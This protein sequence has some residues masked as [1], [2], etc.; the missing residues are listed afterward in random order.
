MGN[1]FQVIKH[2]NRTFWTANTMELFERLAWYGMFIVLANYL[3]GSTDSGALGFSQAEKGLLMGSIVGF[4]Y[5]L[6]ILTGS[7]ADKF[8]Y[9]K[10]LLVAYVIMASGYVMMGMFRSFWAVYFAFFYL[11]IGAALFKPVISATISKTT[12][13]E[14]SSI[15]FGLFYMM[16]NIGAFI[17]PV[18]AS[19]L[20]FLDWKY[21]F[22]MSAA[23]IMVNFFLVLLFY[24]EPKR[25]LNEEPLIQAFKKVFV[26]I[27][28]GIKDIRFL[29]FLILIG[30]FWSMYN[31]LFYTFPVYIEQ[32]VDL[33]KLYQDLF[34]FWP[35]F[36]SA[37]GTANKTVAPEMLV[38]IDA[39]YII[40]FQILVS[41]FVMRFKP[42]KAMIG[43]ILVCSFGIGLSIATRNPF[44]MLFTIWLFAIGE[45]ASSPKITEYIGKIAPPDKVALY[46]GFSFFPVFIGNIVAG[47]LSGPVY[48]RMSDKFTLLKQELT[49]RNISFPEISDSFTQNDLF[50][51]ASNKTGMDL[52][53][54]TNFLYDKYHPSQIWLLFTGIGVISGLLLI[55]YNRFILKDK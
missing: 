35:A 8:G 16:V 24:K 5:F 30:G 21:V 50:R 14:T 43:G 45:M 3:T 1:I 33:E 42:L 2:Y 20:R 6:P 28:T 12:N 51:L 54:L 18:I 55:V 46:M 13:D 47:Y 41:S 25:I 7:I 48:E 26:N 32:W 17:G 44:I 53:E 34:S 39:F 10:V 23:S 38:N 37:V 19:K 9:K 29:I 36:A 31:Q 4:L 22:M 15:G 49:S 52:H 27:W 11:A 40:I